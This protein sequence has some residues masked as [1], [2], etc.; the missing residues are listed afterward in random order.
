MDRTDIGGQLPTD[1]EVVG[2]LAS[3]DDG[4]IEGQG[5][6]V[7]QIAMPGV[8]HLAV[9]SFKNIQEVKRKMLSHMH[10]YFQGERI[11]FVI[12]FLIYFAVLRREPRTQHTLCKH[13]IAMH[14]L[15]SI[16]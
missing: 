14:I 7:I 4:V 8:F 3:S 12:K 6:Q 11:S 9:V 1:P 2:V 5:L 10:S 16:Y 15:S 13:S